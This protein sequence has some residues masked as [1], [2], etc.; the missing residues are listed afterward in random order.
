[1]GIYLREIVFF[2]R[3]RL[4]KFAITLSED[5]SRTADSFLFALAPEDI[6]DSFRQE[7]AR[8]P[9]TLQF[10]FPL[11]LIEITMF[12]T[13]IYFQGAMMTFFFWRCLCIYHL[14]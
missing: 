8:G 5:A 13:S 6:C 4:G 10:L 7:I 12:S 1:M 2:P 14:E 3:C 9:G 11:A